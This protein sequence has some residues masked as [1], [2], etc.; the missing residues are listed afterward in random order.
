VKASGIN[1][2]GAG[3]NMSAASAAQRNVGEAKI[4]S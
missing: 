3:E 4:I 2:L 1:W